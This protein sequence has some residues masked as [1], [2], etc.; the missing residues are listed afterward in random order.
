MLRKG[1]FVYLV[2]CLLI[3]GGKLTWETVNSYIWGLMKISQF[4]KI[5]LTQYSRPLT[6]KGMTHP[7]LK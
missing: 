5:Q 7:F 3:K 1:K 2:L 4:V 6:G